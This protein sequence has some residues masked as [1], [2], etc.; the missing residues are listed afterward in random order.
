MRTTHFALNGF[1]YRFHLAPS[2]D[3]PLCLVP[4]TVGHYLLLCP[5]YRRERLT[6]I[7]KLG[8]ARLSLRGLLAAKS[9]HKPV[10]RFVRETGRFPRY[11][12]Y[13]L[14]RLVIRTI[15]TNSPYS[16]LSSPTFHRPPVPCL[17]ITVC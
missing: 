14:P 6:M 10:L 13:E 3:C 11:A 9:D 5:R 7:L 12:L 2:P 8:T 17:T 4:E 1:L 16:T 15:A